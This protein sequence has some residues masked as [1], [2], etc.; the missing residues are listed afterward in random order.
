MAQ[1]AACEVTAR[2]MSRIVERP[3]PLPTP[4]W[5]WQGEKTEKG[6]GRMKVGPRK[7]RTHRVA[8]RL[9]RGPIPGGIEV[10]HACD[11]R[12]CCRPEHLSLGTTL[13]N[14]RDRTVKGRGANTKLNDDAVRDIRTRRL[15]QTKFAELYRVARGTVQ[16]I[17]RGDS[18]KHLLPPEERPSRDW[19]DVLERVV[20]HSV[21]SLVPGQYTVA[22]FYVTRAELEV[23]RQLLEETSERQRD[24]GFD[25]SVH[26]LRAVVGLPAGVEAPEPD[27]AR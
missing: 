19:V 4:C 23:V 14:A 25:V 15:S 22:P 13:D 3:G 18:W 26:R 10:M 20:G 21:P 12:P 5:V 24:P 8:Y 17:Q 11:N 9:F 27:P 16:A 7:E 1:R 2:L 6:Y